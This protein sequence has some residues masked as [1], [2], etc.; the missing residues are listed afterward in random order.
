MLKLS[1]SK[2]QIIKNALIIIVTILAL[3]FLSYLALNWSIRD[4]VSRKLW[5]DEKATIG[6]IGI[7]LGVLITLGETKLLHK[8]DDLLDRAKYNLQ[9]ALKGNLG[10]EKAFKRLLEM[11]GSS[12]RLYRNFKIPGKRFDIDA[13]VV[14]PKGII[15]IEVKNLSGEYRFIESEVYKISRYPD[16]NTCYCQL[17]RWKS[18]VR[19]AAYHNEALEEWL[20]KNDFSQIKVKGAILMVG[21]RYKIEK[22]EKPEVY[23]IT[24]ADGIKRY[25]DDTFEDS[26]FTPEFCAK[27][28]ELLEKY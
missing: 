3:G 27:L 13:I 8:L 15:T 1:F 4:I 23:I 16:G 26:R 17:G 9:N 21:D 11:L 28:N 20:M 22:I 18:P 25:F 14:G 6:A 24:S 7:L 12:Y 10:E 19:E 5:L 2:R